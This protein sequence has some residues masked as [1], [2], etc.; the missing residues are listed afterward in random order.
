MLSSQRYSTS[1]SKDP[2]LPAYSFSKQVRRTSIFESDLSSPTVSIFTSTDSVGRYRDQTSLTSTESA[3]IDKQPFR[4]GTV[5]IYNSNKSHIQKR[6]VVSAPGQVVCQRIVR[7]KSAFASTKAPWRPPGKW[8]IPDVFITDPLPY[9]PLTSNTVKQRRK[10]L[11]APEA[12]DRFKSRLASKGQCLHKKPW[13]PAGKPPDCL[14]IPKPVS[15]S[16]RRKPHAQFERA[17][18]KLV[19]ES[20]IKEQNPKERYANFTKIGSGANGAVVK[21]TGRQLSKQVYAIKRCFID[22][23]DQPHLAYI[24]RELR[25]MGSFNHD[26]IVAIK[27]VTLWSDHVWI[28]MEIMSCSVFGLLCKISTGLPENIAVYIVQECLHGLIFLHSKGYMHRDV[29]CENLLLSRTGQVKLADFGLA[30]PLNRINNARLGTAKWMAPE[31]IREMEYD[32]KVDVWSTAI[33]M[34]E[35]MDRVPP[36]YYLDNTDD[37]FAEIL[38]GMPAKFSFATPS[39]HMKDLVAW[40]LYTDTRRRPSAKNVLSVQNFFSIA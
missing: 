11:S 28:A 6:I 19:P 31:V 21:A 4:E 24:L 17:M 36:L 2:R 39:E 26:N 23:T 38:W 16:S 3:H 22:D 25:I 14:P 8:Q 33:T 15:R 5:V 29:K 32:E 9:P 20:K 12:T 34:I 18:R 35:M 10:S 40:M 30:S 7:R 27:E 1:T 13:I 37:I